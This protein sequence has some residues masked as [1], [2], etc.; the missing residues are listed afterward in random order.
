MRMFCS[1]VLMLLLLL[2]KVFARHLNVLSRL[3]SL[4]YELFAVAFAVAAAVADTF[5]IL[6][7]LYLH[8]IISTFQGE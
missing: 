5:R 6:G 1:A 4:L 3:F 2:L 7:Y 8:M